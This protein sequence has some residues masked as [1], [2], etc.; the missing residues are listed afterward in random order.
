MPSKPALLAAIGLFIPL[1]ACSGVLEDDVAPKIEVSPRPEG[2]A[3]DEAGDDADQLHPTY[4]TIWG[5]EYYSGPDPIGL[6]LDAIALEKADG[7]LFFATDIDS[8]YFEEDDVHHGQHQA[9]LGPPQGTCDLKDVALFG[10]SLLVFA[11]FADPATDQK[12]PIEPH[13]HL[14]VYALHERQCPQDF[15]VYDHACGAFDASFTT[16]PGTGVGLGCSTHFPFDGEPVRLEIPNI[17]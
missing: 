5:G 12:I 8:V 2:G 16:E 14:L 13:D 1:S 10:E 4:V 9:M 17:Y 11:S 6:K 7:R 15:G 3:G